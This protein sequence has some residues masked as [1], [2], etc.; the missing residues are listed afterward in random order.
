MME[1]TEKEE[2]AEET[3]DF[4]NTSNQQKSLDT[5]SKD[6]SISTGADAPHPTRGMGNINRFS[7]REELVALAN[8]WIAEASDEQEK[9]ALLATKEELLAVLD[10]APRRT[11]LAGIRRL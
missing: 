8:E 5:D 3:S 7:P 2:L 9:K 4:A 11:P 1:N 6:T 10:E